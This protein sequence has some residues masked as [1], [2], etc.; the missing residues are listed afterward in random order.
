M[1][2]A[3]IGDSVAAPHLIEMTR[4]QESIFGGFYTG[5]AT[6]DKNVLYRKRTVGSCS[7]FQ[8]LYDLSELP[9]SIGIAHS[10]TNDGGGVEW[11]QPRFDEK[12]GI[13]SVGVGIGG[14]LASYDNT[15][16]L[17]ESL[18]S[19]GVVFHTR[20]EGEK[21]NGITLSDKTTI[22]AAEAWLIAI[23]RSYDSGRSILEAIR[24]VNLR[25]ESVTLYLTTR[26]PDRIFVAN[27]NSRLLALKTEKGMQLVSSIIGLNEKIIWAME[28]PPNTFATVTKN[29]VITEVLWEDE[30]RYDFYEPHD[31]VSVV[32]DYIND[33]PGAGWADA[34]NSTTSKIFPSGKASLG[35]LMFHQTIERLL[36]NKVIKYETTEVK[37]TEGQC[38]IPQMILFCDK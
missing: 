3:Y 10:R 12:Q 14:V 33:N 8:S 19:Q 36:K 37:G 20:L 1:I 35:F 4:R 6:I 22:H 2:S 31:F 34:L 24:E 15:I 21:K 9:G 18:L 38:G 17:A 7:T 25:S 23:G 27:H 32:T 29:Q 13:A 30:E 16:L 5:I 26:E 28:I 11:A